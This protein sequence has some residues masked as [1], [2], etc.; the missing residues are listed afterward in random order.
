M[1][2]LGMN[3]TRECLIACDMG[4]KCLLVLCQLLMTT[5]AASSVQNLSCLFGIKNTSEALQW[6]RNHVGDATIFCGGT[7]ATSPRGY[8]NAGKIGCPTTLLNFTIPK[9]RSTEA[10]NQAFM[11][12]CG[13]LSPACAATPAATCRVLPHVSTGHILSQQLSVWC[14]LRMH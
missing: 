1:A 2:S 9:G 3:S 10:V 6:V 5:A 12:F 13:E 8:C 14:C 7:M 11:H 4:T